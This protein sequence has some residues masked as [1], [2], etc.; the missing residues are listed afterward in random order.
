MRKQYSSGICRKSLE[1][2]LQG[3]GSKGH[4]KGGKIPLPVNTSRPSARQ[5]RERT[6]RIFGVKPAMRNK[7]GTLASDHESLNEG[8]KGSRKVGRCRSHRV[9]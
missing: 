7:E 6:H 9:T 3:G 5:F 1:G 2:I 8:Q 4:S